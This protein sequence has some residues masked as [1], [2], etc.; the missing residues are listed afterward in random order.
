[1]TKWK[2]TIHYSGFL[3]AS[4]LFI[5]FSPTDDSINPN[6][7]I[8]INYNRRGRASDETDLWSFERVEIV[9]VVAKGDLQHTDLRHM[10]LQR[11]LIYDFR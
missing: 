9:F 2:T 7:K 4:R 5:S 11:S 8:K 6:D 3:I 10:I 1:M